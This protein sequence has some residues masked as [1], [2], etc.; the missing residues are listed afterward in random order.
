M[1]KKVYG[2]LCGIISMIAVL[3]FFIWGMIE[4]SYEH[5]WMVFIVSGIACAVLGM[6]KSIKDGK[7]IN[8]KEDEGKKE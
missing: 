2:A 6:I 5:S 8:E 7:E 4:G 3:A 1:N